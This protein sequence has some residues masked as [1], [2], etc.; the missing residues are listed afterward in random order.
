MALLHDIRDTQAALA[1]LGSPE[2]ATGPRRQSLNQFLAA[3]P[4]LWR[5]GE[6]RSTHRQGSSGPRT[7]RT[8]KDPFEGVWTDVLLW[9]REQL[10][11]TAKTLFERLQSECPRRFRNGQLR[12]LQRRLR[13][14]RHVLARELVYGASEELAASEVVLVGG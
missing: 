1:A 4:G 13:Q 11:A 5:A 14:W 10:D 12:T 9:L 6:A 8:R 3:L 2:D 7:W